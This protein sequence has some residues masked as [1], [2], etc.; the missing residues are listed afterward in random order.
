VIH[1]VADFSGAGVLSLSAV[2]GVRIRDL[3]ILNDI[4]RRGPEVLA[5]DR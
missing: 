2:S 3:A 1:P 4:G 5:G